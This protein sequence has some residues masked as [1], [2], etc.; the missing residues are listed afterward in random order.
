MAR[1]PISE[2]TT[3]VKLVV[4]LDD[5]QALNVVKEL[6]EIDL[7]NLSREVAEAGGHAI[8][9]GVAAARTSAAARRVELTLNV[10]KASKAKKFREEHA[11]LG[12]KYTVDSIKDDVTLDEEVQKGERK[13]IDAYEKSNILQAVKTAVE[14]KNR[15]VGNLTAA[16]TKELDLKTLGRQAVPGRKE[17]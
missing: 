12:E 6:G 17:V 11:R 8:W 14:Q 15:T 10:L 4:K 5:D 13:L 3:A 1:E 2:E 16:I 7:D 9:F